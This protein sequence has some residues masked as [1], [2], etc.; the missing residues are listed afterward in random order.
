MRQFVRAARSTHKAIRRLLVFRKP[1]LINILIPG[2]KVFS[3]W[4]S[5]PRRFVGNLKK[6]F[7]ALANL[8]LAQ[9]WAFFIGSRMHFPL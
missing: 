7:G 4:T 8:R 5:F 1:Q 3:A 9:I 6:D 2:R